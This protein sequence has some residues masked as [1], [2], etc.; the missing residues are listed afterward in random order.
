[1]LTAK[2]QAAKRAKTNACKAAKAAYQRDKTA[3]KSSQLPKQVKSK[4]LQQL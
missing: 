4:A 3:E 2:A 1:M